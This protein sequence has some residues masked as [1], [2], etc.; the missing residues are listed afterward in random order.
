MTTDSVIFSTHFDASVSPQ[1]AGAKLIKR[2][3]SD[4]AAMGGVPADAV[5]SL[6]MSRDIKIE[7]L[8]QFYAG[9]AQACAGLG[10]EL[11]GGDVASAPAGT[12]IFIATL[13][14][15]GFCENEPLLRT[16]AQI[17]DVVFVTGTLGGS[18]EKKHF[19]F[20]PRLKEGEFLASFPREKIRACMDITDGLAKDLREIVPANAHI[21]FD[22]PQFRFPTKRKNFPAA[23]ANSRSNTH[24][25]TAKTTNLFFASQRN[26]NQRLR[27]FGGNAFR[28]HPWQE[29]GKLPP[30]PHRSRNSGNPPPATNIFVKNFAPRAK[31]LLSPDKHNFPLSSRKP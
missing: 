14:L 12:Q 21:E 6:V 23:I 25:A 28:K 20:T 15:T 22:F 5:L 30:E 8:E 29:S 31:A 9:M 16:G 13:T 3:A 4:I 26:S 17:G 10:I 27:L 24:F 1:A 2:N 7:W 19:A 11:A 18:I